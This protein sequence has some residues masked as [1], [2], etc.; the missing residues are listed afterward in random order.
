MDEWD[1]RCGRAAAQVMKNKRNDSKQIK[2][3]KQN[4][5]QLHFLHQT[6]E[7]EAADFVNREGVWPVTSPRVRMTS[8]RF[9]MLGDKVS[10][11]LFKGRVHPQK[12]RSSFCASYFISEKI[13]PPK[14]QIATLPPG[15]HKKKYI[16][17]NRHRWRK[18]DKETRAFSRS[19]NQVASRNLSTWLPNR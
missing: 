19:T 12:V 8:D 13:P 10:P 5:N 7:N 3:N 18:R 17:T 14:N 16:H 6:L 2:K 15:R 1:S 9:K 11:S 4:I